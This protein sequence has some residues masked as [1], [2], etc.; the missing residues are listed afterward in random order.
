[1]EAKGG[2]K[3]ELVGIPDVMKELAEQKEE[4]KKPDTNPGVLVFD[5]GTETKAVP[6]KKPALSSEKKATLK[7]FSAA[8]AVGDSAKKSEGEILRDFV[9]KSEVSTASV[10]TQPQDKQDKP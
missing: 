2:V 8:K 3:F 6:W 4:K 7:G 9:R 1:M 5:M 10:R